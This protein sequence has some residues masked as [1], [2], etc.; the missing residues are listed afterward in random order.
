MVRERDGAEELAI[1]VRKEIIDG[2]NGPKKV[3]LIL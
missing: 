3:P 2:N 1:T